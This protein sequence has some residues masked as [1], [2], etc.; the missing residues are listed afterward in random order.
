MSINYKKIMLH[1]CLRIGPHHDVKCADV[2]TLSGCVLSWV[3]EPRY[4]GVYVISS[5]QF[6]ISLQIAKRSF[7]RAANN[8]F[9]IKWVESPLRRSLYNLLKASTCIPAL[10]YGLEACPLTKSD[11]RSLDFVINGYFTKLF[12]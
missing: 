3:C 10:L 2:V 5:R 1:C 6:K 11:I 4:L 8:I 9:G 7:Y 12:K